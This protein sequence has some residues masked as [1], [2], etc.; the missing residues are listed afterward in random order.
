MQ[1]PLGEHEKERITSKT[2]M[3]LTDIT[4]DEVMK[5]H[6]SADDIKISREMLKAC[7]LY[8]S[9]RYAEQTYGFNPAFLASASICC[10]SSKILTS[11]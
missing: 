4:L 6:I 5:N 9:F 10:A 1:Y 7:L 8:T 11:T 3:K 2:G